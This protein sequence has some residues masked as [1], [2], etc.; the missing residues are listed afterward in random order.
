MFE[1]LTLRLAFL[2]KT[3]S[4]FDQI[5]TVWSDDADA[6]K[7]PCELIEMSLIKDLCES[8]FFGLSLI[9]SRSQINKV[10]SVLAVTSCLLCYNLSYSLGLKASCAIVSP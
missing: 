8:S 4:V 9:C 5:L 1:D 6:I 7:V 10:L 3:Y 2:L